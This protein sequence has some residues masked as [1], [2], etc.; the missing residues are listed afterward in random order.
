MEV[1]PEKT[2]MQYALKLPKLPHKMD[3]IWDCE[4]WVSKIQFPVSWY[5]IFKYEAKILMKLD[6]K[7]TMANISPL[8]CL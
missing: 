3:L 1:F 2:F 8:K 7:K 6:E 4:V 5:N